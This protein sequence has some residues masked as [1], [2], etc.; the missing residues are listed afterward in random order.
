MTSG[1][2][3]S[4]P[5]LVGMRRLPGGV[6][7]MGSDHFYPEERPRRRVS[8][9]AFWIDETAVTNRQFAQFVA[10]TGYRTFAEIAPNPADYPGMPA[11]LARAGSLLFERPATPVDLN[12]WQ[13]WW[14]FR[15]GANW[16][17][18]LGEGLLTPVSKSIPFCTSPMSDAEAYAAWAGKAL[19]TEAEWEYAA[20]GGSDTEYAW[21]DE[22]AP[23]GRMLANYWQGQ[24]PYENR[25]LDG[26]ERTSPVRS[27]PANGFGLYDMIGNVWEWTCD[28]YAIAALQ[29]TNPPAA[30]ASPPTHAAG[31]SS[32]ATIRTTPQLRIGRK[33]HQRWL[34]LCAPNYCQRYR[35]AARSAQPI[36]TSTSHLG[37][38]CV[39]RERVSSGNES[40]STCSHSSALLARSSPR[41][42]CAWP[43]P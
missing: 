3:H 40:S 13:R 8:V 9:A 20:R 36:D 27:F 7:T 17:Q 38:R 39:V 6:F 33:V 43:R 21:G 16:R 42:C 14:Q 19:P 30:A 31:A 23:E 34:A 10:A 26:W 32:R 18:P 11:E 29:A 28:W 22:L 2:S 1:K 4:E 41:R 5:V 25:M 24:F 12:D 37:F 35:P 15:F